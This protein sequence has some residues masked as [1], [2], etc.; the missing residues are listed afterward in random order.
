MIRSY[1]ANLHW[2][3][4]PVVSMGLFIAVFLGVVIWVNRKGSD[5]VYNQMKNIVL[6][7]NSNNG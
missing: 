3:V 5:K 6:E 2:S 1:L 4:L 7:G